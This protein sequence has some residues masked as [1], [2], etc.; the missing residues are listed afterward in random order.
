MAQEVIEFPIAGKVVSVSCKL[1]EVVKEGDTICTIESMKME[2]PIVSPVSGKV[3]KI[4]LTVGKV[5]ESG[6]LV[7]VIEY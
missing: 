7:A 5:V 3:V 1:G 4:E 2:L 6:E